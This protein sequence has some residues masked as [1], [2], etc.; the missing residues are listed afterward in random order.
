[1]AE[2]GPRNPTLLVLLPQS[3]SSAPIKYLYLS[4]TAGKGMDAEPVPFRLSEIK[5]AVSEVAEEIVSPR[6]FHTGCLE[7]HEKR[8]HGSHT[9]RPIPQDRW[10]KSVRTNER[11]FA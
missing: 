1:M 10:D 6:H 8:T 3:Y 4:L 5:Y 9:I 7:A 11:Q 2:Q